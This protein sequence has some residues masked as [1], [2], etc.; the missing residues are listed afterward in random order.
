MT[1]LNCSV[2]CERPWWFECYFRRSSW[3]HCWLPLAVLSDYFGQLVTSTFLLCKFRGLPGSTPVR[4]PVMRRWKW[5]RM[6]KL[7]QPSSTTPEKRAGFNLSHRRKRNLSPVSEVCQAVSI[8]LFWPTTASTN[9]R[10]CVSN[11]PSTWLANRQWPFNR[12]IMART[13]LKKD[14]GIVSQKDLTGSLVFFCR[15][16]WWTHRKCTS[17]AKFIRRSYGT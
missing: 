4:F 9:Y 16:L 12:P 11:F 5:I 14:F 17:P 13:Q 7:S 6:K 10:K 2:I 15:H 8:S 3:I 1:S